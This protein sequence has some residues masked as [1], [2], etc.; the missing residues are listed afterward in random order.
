MEWTF[1]YCGGNREARVYF[2]YP[3]SEEDVVVSQNP[4]V[5]YRTEIVQ[6]Q[7]APLGGM[8]QCPV[9]YE[10]KVRIYRRYANGQVYDSIS[11]PANCASGFFGPIQGIVVEQTGT[12]SIRMGI[13]GRDRNARPLTLYRFS[14]GGTP[15]DWEFTFISIRRC[16]NQPDSCGTTESQCKFTVTDQTG[17][18][19]TR[20]SSNCPQVRIE[21]GKKCPPNTCECRRGRDVCCFNSQGYVVASFKA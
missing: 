10:V 11:T 4:P 17:L 13:A 8:G 2:K 18:I 1:G 12:N 20:T 16:D 9:A 14:A 19:Y 5:L 7:N 21:C 3:G 6:A 15:S